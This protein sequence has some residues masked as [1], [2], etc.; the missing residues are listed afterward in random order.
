[1][2]DNEKQFSTHLLPDGEWNNR[3]TRVDPNTR[4][5]TRLPLGATVR[6]LVEYE[7][8]LHT[9]IFNFVKDG[10]DESGEDSYRTALFAAEPPLADYAIYGGELNVQ[11]DIIKL[12]EEFTLTVPEHI[13]LAQTT[14]KAL[15]IEANVASLFSY[16]DKAA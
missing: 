2:T 9:L 5:N 6:V 12:H 11:G 14:F 16:K 4:E 10:K 3:I 8:S 1:M 7:N 15:A 13:M